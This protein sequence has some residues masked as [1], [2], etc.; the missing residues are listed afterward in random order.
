M[1]MH[2]Q[3]PMVARPAACAPLPPSTTTAGCGGGD[4]GP[5]GGWSESY[6]ARAAAAA[7]AF[8]AAA[9]GRHPATAPPAGRW[10]CLAGPVAGGDAGAGLPAAPQ[11]ATPHADRS[12]AATA[13]ATAAA[14]ALDPFH[15]DWPHW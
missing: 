2:A 9:S 1:A 4:G 8:A 5:G 12:V 11:H 6:P 10:E 3:P 13:T 15:G 14:A 7:A